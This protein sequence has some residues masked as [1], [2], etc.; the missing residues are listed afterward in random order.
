[1]LGHLPS[2]YPARSISSVPKARGAGA[3]S[4][5]CLVTEVEDCHYFNKNQLLFVLI[6]GFNMSFKPQ[7]LIFHTPSSVKDGSLK[8]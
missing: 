8:F 3:G 1:M 5:S 2:H 7:V 6:I 4:Y